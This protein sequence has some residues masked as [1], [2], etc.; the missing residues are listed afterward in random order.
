MS[1]SVRS[2]AEKSTRLISSTI[3]PLEIW[4]TPSSYDI[5]Q[6]EIPVSSFSTIVY[7]MD[8]QVSL[9]RGTEAACSHSSKTTR[10]M[11]PSYPSSKS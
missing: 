10:I 11:M 2:A 7:V 6:L 8:M 3:V 9:L 5:D 1:E 4:D